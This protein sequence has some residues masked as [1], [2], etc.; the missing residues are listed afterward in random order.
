M[1]APTKQVI[2]AGSMI[3]FYDRC[4][5]PQMPTKQSDKTKLMSFRELSIYHSHRS[6]IFFYND[7]SFSV[8]E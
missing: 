4:I 2:T 8:I 6:L 1:F 5:H 7:H 3:C